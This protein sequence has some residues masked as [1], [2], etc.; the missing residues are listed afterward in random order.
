MNVAATPAQTATPA[1]IAKARVK[2]ASVGIPT[3]RMAWRRFR[4]I[5]RE[6]WQRERRAQRNGTEGVDGLSPSEGLLA[7]ETTRR[8]SPARVCGN[9]S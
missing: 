3:W 1:E 9:V 6:G 4:P 8:R 5:E 2:P 7:S